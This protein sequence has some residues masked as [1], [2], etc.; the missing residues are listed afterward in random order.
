MFAVQGPG[1]LVLLFILLMAWV[2]TRLHYPRA[3][4]TALHLT[5]AGLGYFLALLALLLLGCPAA[6]ALVRQFGLAPLLPALFA[7]A[8]WFLGTYLLFIPLHRLLRARGMGV[9][10]ADGAAE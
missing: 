7:Q 1:I 5:R 10:R 2:R 8:A 3:P 6:P 4:G 9:F